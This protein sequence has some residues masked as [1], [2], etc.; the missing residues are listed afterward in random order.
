MKK[1]IIW[2]DDHHNALGLLRM[3]GG[4][5]FDILFLVHE[6]DNGIATVSKFCSNYYVVD[7]IEAGLQYLRDNYKDPV[8]KAVL[9]FTADKFSEAANSILNSLKDYFYVSGPEEE[10]LLEQIDDKYTMGMLAKQCGINIPQT[11]LIPPVPAAPDCV[12]P[13]IIKPCSPKSKDFKTQI[14]RNSRQYDE[15]KKRLMPNRRYVLQ[16]FVNK[17]ADG[18]IY[19]C[20]DQNGQTH[21]AGICVRDR[22][23]DDGCGSFGYITPEI[24]VAINQKGIADFLEK[25][26][27]RGIFSVEYALTA[28]DAYFYEFN[29]R[30]DGTA[31]LFY[32][33]GSNIA[34]H[35]VNSC[36]GIEPSAPVRVAG[37]QY[38]INEIRDKFNVYDRNIT[39]KRWKEDKKKATLFFYYDPDDMKPYENQLARYNWL[40]FHHIVAKT[41]INKIRLR[42]IQKLRARQ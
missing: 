18:L 11:I 7:S 21:L 15:V 2:G 14:V 27:F 5:G 12:F 4:R 3:L 20:R 41:W 22:W 6:K 9:L 36:F 37:K 35:Y 26:K 40:L 10:G 33:A 29:L 25:I 39:L 42:I 24:P 28:D 30:N 38:L 8:D 1:I 23:S 32:N 19:G 34:L 13:S 17:D 31:V 16:S